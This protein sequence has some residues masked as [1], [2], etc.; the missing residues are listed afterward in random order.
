[1]EKFRPFAP[2]VLEEYASEYFEC[3]EPSPYMLF[4]FQVEQ[5]KQAVIPAVT[6]VDGSHG[7]RRCHA[8]T[9]RC[10]MT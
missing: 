1:R 7:F 8:T 9:I 3:H 2:V 6:H 5:S 4:N 10:T